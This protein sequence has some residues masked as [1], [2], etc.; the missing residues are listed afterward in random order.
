M[1]AVSLDFGLSQF[2]GVC[3]AYDFNS[4]ISEFY[5]RLYGGI[6]YHLNIVNVLNV[7]NNDGK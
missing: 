3:I 2:I 7:S 4:I 6:M 5:S 1:E